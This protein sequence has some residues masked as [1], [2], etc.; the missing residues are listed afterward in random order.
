MTTLRQRTE[1]ERY[2]VEW[3][4]GG[5]IIVVP[6]L[7]QIERVMVV[8][9]C[10]GDLMHLFYCEPCRAHLANVYNLRLHLEAGGDHRIATWC[11]KRRVY[12]AIS[13][14][15]FREITTEFGEDL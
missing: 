6:K 13:S 12:E 10:A 7:D 1:S 2:T 9:P 8:S 4:R 11:D 14:A 5:D 3:L 15:Q